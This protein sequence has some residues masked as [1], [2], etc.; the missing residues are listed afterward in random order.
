ME[1]LGSNDQDKFVTVVGSE[2]GIL[3]STTDPLNLAAV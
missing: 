3:F 2:D 1:A